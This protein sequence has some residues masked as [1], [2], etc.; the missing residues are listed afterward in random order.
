MTE[1]PRLYLDY[2]VVLS[3]S[4]KE[5]AN[6]LSEREK[7][8]ELVTDEEK[9]KLKRA[10]LPSFILSRLQVKKEG[11]AL[12][13]SYLPSA[14]DPKDKIQ[15]FSQAPKYMAP[16]EA[17][18]RRRSS[19]EEISKLIGDLA[20]S[21]GALQV[22]TAEAAKK[23]EILKQSS[24]EIMRVSTNDGRASRRNSALVMQH[25]SSTHIDI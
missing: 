14:I 13:C 9:D 23:V 1:L 4:K 19:T 15:I 11:D 25:Q 6:K 20:V 21:S 24:D 3:M 17:E 8:G 16:V 12:V 18:Q 2:S 5:V 7:A 10:A 22:A